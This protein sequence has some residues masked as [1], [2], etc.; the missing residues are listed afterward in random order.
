MEGFYSQIT[1]D[2]MY[3]FIDVCFQQPILSLISLHNHICGAGGGVYVH[4]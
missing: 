2:I 3:F 1:K 4:R